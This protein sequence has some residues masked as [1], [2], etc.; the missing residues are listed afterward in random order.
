MVLSFPSA[1]VY[2]SAGSQR[3]GLSCGINE[4]LLAPAVI[5]PPPPS[6]SGASGKAEVERTKSCN[7]QVLNGAK[8]Q[9]SQPRLAE[10][11]SWMQK[12][13]PPGAVILGRVWLPQPS[14]IQGRRQ[15]S[16]EVWSSLWIALHSFCAVLYPTEPIP[17]DGAQE[18]CVAG[19]LSGDSNALLGGE[20]LL[21]RMVFK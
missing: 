17:A 7:G 15:R 3:G 2:S 8:G 16:P 4:P 14:V 11:E 12:T 19:N 6:E 18:S 10:V 21:P 5:P 9:L 13:N 1:T 20:A